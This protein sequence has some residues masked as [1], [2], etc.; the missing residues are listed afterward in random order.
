M[1]AEVAVL[2][3]EAI[4]I[5]ADSAVTA[6][7]VSGQKIFASANKIFAISKYHPVGIMIYD[8]ANMVRF[9]WETLVKAYRESLGKES[10]PKLRDYADDFFRFLRSDTRIALPSNQQFFVEVSV[11]SYFR[12]IAEQI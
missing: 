5:A 4:A 1:T 3:R 11:G 9:P 8:S 6:G 12:T 2:N 10:F 7:L